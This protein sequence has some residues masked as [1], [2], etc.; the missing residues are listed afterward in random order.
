M[1]NCILVATATIIT[2]IHLL[3]NSCSLQS[4]SAG[5]LEDWLHSATFRATATI[6]SRQQLMKEGV[7]TGKVAVRRW[8]QS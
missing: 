8:W 2:T 6:V 3:K 1:V 5:R 4:R 7:L